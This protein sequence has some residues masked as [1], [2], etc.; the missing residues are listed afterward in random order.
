MLYYTLSVYGCLGDCV[1]V[2][3]KYSTIKKGK[4]ASSSVLLTRQRAQCE[5][6]A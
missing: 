5:E 6:C 3:V 2:Y 4:Y 1:F